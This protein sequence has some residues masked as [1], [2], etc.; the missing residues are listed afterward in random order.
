M[1]L[2]TSHLYKLSLTTG[3]GCSEVGLLPPQTLWNQSQPFVE[4]NP[5]SRGLHPLVQCNQ[6]YKER[7]VVVQSVANLP[8]YTVIQPI[9]AA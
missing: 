4:P 9:S 8:T 6:R 2:E 7:L 5:S 1:S 3:Q